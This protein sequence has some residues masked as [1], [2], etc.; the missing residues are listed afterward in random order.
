VSAKQSPDAG[1]LQQDKLNRTV[2]YSRGVYLYYLS[3][4]LQPVEIACLGK[5][6]AYWRGKD[7]LD[8]GVG[9]GR[10]S[11]FLVSAAR[12]YV[13]VDYSPVMVRHVKK[14]LPGIDVRQVDFRDLSSFENESFD[15]VLATA[16]VIDALSHRDRLLAL[17]ESSRVLRPNG[18][19]AFSTHNLNYKLAFA[20]PRLNWSWNP[21][22]LSKNAIMY[23]VGSWN[24][25]K[26]GPLRTRT[27]EYAVLNDTGH[28]YACLH[29]YAARSTVRAQLASAGIRQLDVFDASGRALLDADDDSENAWLF[30]VGQ[31]A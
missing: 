7:I 30:Y 10:T 21:V 18:I 23:A 26:I 13:A 2:Y 29:Y 1:S 17:Q 4:S 20:G 14:T 6:E 8:I 22:R 28:F 25:R 24:Y 5:Y 31:R 11:R 15:F 19:L 16:N 27:A 12:R 3:K 9:A